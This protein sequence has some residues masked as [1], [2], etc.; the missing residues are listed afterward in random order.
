[1]VRDK[2]YDVTNIP[3]SV[4]HILHQ[5]CDTFLERLSWWI[6]LL[7]LQCDIV[8]S[9]TLF[10]I[11][12]NFPVVQINSNKF[13]T[14][15]ASKKWKHQLDTVQRYL[16]DLLVNGAHYKL[17]VIWI[18]CGVKVF[19][20]CFRFQISG[21]KQHQA[22]DRLACPIFFL[23]CNC[24]FRTILLHLLEQTMTNTL[25]ETLAVVTYFSGSINVVEHRHEQGYSL[26]LFWIYLS[27]AQKLLNMSENLDRCEFS[28]NCSTRTQLAH[29]RFHTILHTR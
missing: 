3:K 15:H 2:V 29:H 16:S 21:R 5:L 7:R 8:L 10:G 4:V 18:P 19:R 11:S 14:L 23:S 27:N 25:A 28:K 12:V 9:K 1:M 26:K 13:V 20:R 22:F 24:K 6:V 17:N